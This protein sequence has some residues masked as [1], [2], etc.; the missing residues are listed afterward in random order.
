MQNL[1]WLFCGSGEGESA[2]AA[3]VPPDED[4]GASPVQQQSEAAPAAK[5][6]PTDIPAAPGKPCLL[7]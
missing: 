1:T 2:G 5:P 6:F 4:E 3:H 7:L